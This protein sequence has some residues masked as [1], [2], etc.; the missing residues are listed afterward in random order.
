VGGEFFLLSEAKLQEH[1][2]M[3]SSP[4]IT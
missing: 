1:E 3:E 2:V 4:F